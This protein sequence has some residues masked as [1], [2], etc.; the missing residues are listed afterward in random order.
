MTREKYNRIK[1]VMTE[2]EIGV[3]VLA[4]AIGKHPQ[5]IIAYRNNV[6]QPPLKILFEIAKVLE[7]GPCELL[8]KTS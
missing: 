3:E 6:K 1:A 7:V 2:K 4:K 5:S 8:A